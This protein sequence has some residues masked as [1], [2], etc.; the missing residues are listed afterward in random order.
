MAFLPKMSNDLLY[1]IALTLVPGVGSITAKKLIAYCGSAQA[2]LKSDKLQLQKVPDV[3]Q[4]TAQSISTSDALMHAEEEMEFM[5]KNN[6]R[7][8]FYLDKNYPER[9]R[10]CEDSPIV[11]YVK[12]NTDL[13]QQKIISVVG[14]RQATVRGVQH[15]E[16]L[17]RDFSE[18]GYKPL[19][20]SGLAFGIDVAAHKAALKY[21]LPTVAALGHGLQKVYPPEHSGIA[22]EMLQA[23]GA[24]LTDFT[25]Q[26]KMDPANFVRR[27]RII[28]GMADCTIVVESAEQGGSLITANLA[29]DYARDVMAYPGRVGDKISAGC[30]KL[31]KTNKA[32]LIEG[33]ADVAY[34]LGWDIPKKQG[35]QLPLFTAP[36]SL[37][38]Q[39]LVDL[40]SG[41]ESESI[42]IICRNTGLSMPTASASLLNLE[43]N[44]LIKTLPGKRY[45][46]LKK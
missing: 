23:G 33:A 13:N 2:A 5:E 12:G 14:T 7:A 22:N 40:L 39:K 42:D 18:S 6:I 37:D 11:L 38:E 31:I 27:N 32:A 28:A 30:L 29:F 16:N 26:H 17:M 4:V 19:V 15:C 24:L 8:L 46:L 1:Q 3:G 21:G 45:M 36:L 34:N 25:S 44:G 20:I 43:F 35:K 41:V 9:L 10:N